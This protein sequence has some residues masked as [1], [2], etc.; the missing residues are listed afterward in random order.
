MKFRTKT[1]MMTASFRDVELAGQQGTITG[2]ALGHG[3]HQGGLFFRFGSSSDQRF[4]DGVKVAFAWVVLVVSA[5]VFAYAA[6][7]WR[8]AQED[9]DARVPLM[10]PSSSAT[11]VMA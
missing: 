2:V 11:G 8:N 7:Q 6:V 4:S 9:V 3:N 5:L 1:K 10:F